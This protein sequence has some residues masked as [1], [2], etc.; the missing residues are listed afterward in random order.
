MR[1]RY[2]RVGRAGGFTYIELLVSSG[3]LLLIALALVT[4]NISGARVSQ[5]VSQQYDAM[6]LARGVTMRLKL[7]IEEASEVIV[8]A[9]NFGEVIGVTNGVQRGNAINLELP[10]VG[11]PGVSDSVI[12]YVHEGA[13][14][15]CMND[16]ST[17]IEV[18]VPDLVTAEP[19]MQVDPG[20]VTVDGL[21]AQ[22]LTNRVG[23]AL[24]RVELGL[25][26]VG[27]QSKVVGPG[28]EF[29]DQVITFFALQRGG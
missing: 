1:M 15:R 22:P 19:F 9:G 20:S 11:Q 27:G 2:Q 24:I 28:T 5:I 16:D 13:L 18:V 14:K 4:S 17:A 8:G 12:Y 25:S 3:I 6:A 21:G 23:R 10:R 26:T 29:N 7:E